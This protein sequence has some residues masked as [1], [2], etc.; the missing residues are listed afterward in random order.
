LDF[1]VAEDRDLLVG[2]SP[3]CAI[4]V[5]AQAIIL[6]L[7]FPRLLDGLAWWSISKMLGMKLGQMILR[8]QLLR[9]DASTGR[10]KATTRLAIVAS[11]LRGPRCIL[12]RR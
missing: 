3:L 12:K 1:A 5:V 6:V 10:T 8:C 2:E 4:F 9:Y 11:Y 7:L